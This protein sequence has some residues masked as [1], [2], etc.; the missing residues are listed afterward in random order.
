[1]DM[2]LIKPGLKG[3]VKVS[4]YLFIAQFLLFVAY[5]IFL[6]SSTEFNAPSSTIDW[7]DF[8]SELS[9]NGTSFFMSKIVLLALR[10]SYTLSFVGVAI[11]FW[12]KNKV[13]AT[14]LVSFIL[15]SVAIINTAQLMGMAIIPFAQDH[16]LA[17]AN[18]ESVRIASIEATVQGIYTV[19]EYLDTFVN[20][21]TFNGLF[22]CL[23]IISNK[24][25]G[26]RNIKWLIPIMFIIPYNKFFDLPELI[27]LGAGLLNVVVTALYFILM[28]IFLLNE[29]ESHSSRAAD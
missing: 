14:F 8:L 18:G 1:M 10:T 17:V 26:L 15:V 16:A 5:V 19:Q 27:S 2:K 11:I 23:F 28:G 3:L 22:I 12:E 20:T 4:G 7:R 13:A 24:E 29:N 25:H 9:Q 21:V 6:I